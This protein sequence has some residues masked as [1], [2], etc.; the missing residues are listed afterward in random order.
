MDIIRVICSTIVL[1]NKLKAIFGGQDLAL[2]R[3]C[4][5]LISSLTTQRLAVLKTI[6]RKS[7]IAITLSRNTV[8]LMQVK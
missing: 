7:I 3:Q 5:R 4:I 1:T 2:M 8:R 6:F